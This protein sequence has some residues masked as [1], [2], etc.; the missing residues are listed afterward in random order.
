[1]NPI[2]VFVESGKKRTFAG[3]VYWPGWCRAGRDEAGA[4]R[5]LVEYGPRYARVLHGCVARGLDVQ[6]VWVDGQPRLVGGMLLADD[7]AEAIGR[8]A[9]WAER[10][11]DV[12][13]PNPVSTSGIQ[14]T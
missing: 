4:L 13:P 12:W 5:A 1:M 10:H 8:A 6:E 3:A 2:E 9:S 7:V 14:R 11:P